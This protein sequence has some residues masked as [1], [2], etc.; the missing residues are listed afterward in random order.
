MNYSSK[1]WCLPADIDTDNLAPGAYMKLPVAQIATHTLESV[2]AEFAASVRVGDVIVAGP[3]FGIGSSR[4]QAAGVLVELGVRAVIAPSFSG[5]FFRNAFNLGLLLLTCPQAQLIQ[6]E[7]RIN[8]VEK[9][10]FLDDHTSGEQNMKSHV[11]MIE[12][13]GGHRL[14]CRPIP[15]F[16]MHMIELGG[17][18]NVLKFKIQN[19]LI[20]INT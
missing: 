9:T 15:D 20:K 10:R 4:E 5:L 11:Y 8:I 3:N 19:Q 1:V 2:R 17:L 6:E 13:S 16:L 18:I 7:E 14:E 12:T